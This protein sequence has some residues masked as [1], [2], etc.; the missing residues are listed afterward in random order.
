MQAGDGR[1]RNDHEE[2]DA[3]V[4]DSDRFGGLGHHVCGVVSSNANQE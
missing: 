1:Q 3:V 4:A 2:N